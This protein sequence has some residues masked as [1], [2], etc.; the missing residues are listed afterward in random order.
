MAV[1]Q[2]EITLLVPV[3]NGA[4]FVA[5]TLQSIRNQ[6]LGNLQVHIS[7]DASNDDS[8]G[9]CKHA[10]QLDNRFKVTKTV[11]RLGWVGNINNLIRSI[12]TPFFCIIPQDDIIDKVYL[13]RLFSEMKN[14]ETAIAF[15]DVQEFGEAQRFFSEC[16]LRGDAIERTVRFLLY[17]QLAL[18]FRGL[19]RT[20]SATKP[21]SP[22]RFP[23]PITDYLWLLEIVK[24]GCFIQVP[25]LLYRK[26]RHYSNQIYGWSKSSA[27]SFA[28]GMFLYRRMLNQIVSEQEH[29]AGN[30]WTLSAA[31]LCNYLSMLEMVIDQRGNRSGTKIV[32][33]WSRYQIRSIIQDIPAN[34]QGIKMEVSNQLVSRVIRLL[35]ADGS[36]TQ[37]QHLLDQAA[38]KIKPEVRKKFGAK[39]LVCQRNYQDA[40]EV[41]N[42]DSAIMWDDETQLL[43][44]RICRRTNRLDQASA[45]LK[46]LSGRPDIKEKVFAELSRLQL[47][48]GEEALASKTIEDAYRINPSNR[49][50]SRLRRIVND[51]R[52]SR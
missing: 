52:I 29:G 5:E 19:I 51:T 20:S 47:A 34:N 12:Q 50:I 45:I 26:R 16:S 4:K 37:A 10:E 8:L 28:K 15:S 22:N 43:L 42:E 27:F 48:M 2:P 6:T 18:P 1:A 30:R 14:S 32:R 11:R 35:L 41:L 13:E 21:I 25:E 46:A 36:I 38:V 9:I 33:A 39:I 49:N 31:K 23:G 17:H 44:A 3:Y 40:F 24:N 7:V